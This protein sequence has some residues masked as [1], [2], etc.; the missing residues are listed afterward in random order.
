MHGSLLHEGHGTPQAEDYQSA[1]SSGDR[2]KVFLNDICRNE[3]GLAAGTPL[4]TAVVYGK[5]DGRLP[6][7]GFFDL[8]AEKDELKEIPEDEWRYCRDRERDVLQEYAATHRVPAWYL[9]AGRDRLTGTRQKP[10]DRRVTGR[11]H[12]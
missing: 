9:A 10:P 8:A 5:H 1:S 6:G 2:F 3:F 7:A 4:L 12:M 11:S